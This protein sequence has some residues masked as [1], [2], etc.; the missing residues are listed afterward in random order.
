MAKAYSKVKLLLT[1]F[2]LIMD[3]NV[4][5]IYCLDRGNDASAAA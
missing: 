3:E 5:K 4:G 2:I 1:K